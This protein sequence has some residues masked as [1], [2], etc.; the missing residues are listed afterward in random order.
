MAVDQF[1][2]RVSEIPM[3]QTLASNVRGRVS[4]ILV[5][6]SSER[7]LEVGGIVY[8]KGSEDEN[9]GAILIE[10]ALEV[11]GDPDHTFQVSA[12]DIVGEMQQLNE[13]GQRTAKVSVTE[14]AVLLEFF[15]HDFV[16]AL[17][18]HAVI[19]QDERAKIKEAFRA[20]AGDRLKEL[21]E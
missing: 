3:L 19:T 11:R 2:D 4:D 20:C 16:R 13:F 15:W 7:T 21:T 14:K 5:D 9:T 10:G 12:P 8:E 6:I 1:R 18:E 17:K